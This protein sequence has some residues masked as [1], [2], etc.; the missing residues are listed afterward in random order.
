[1]YPDLDGLLPTGSL[2][3]SN[4]VLVVREPQIDAASVNVELLAQVFRCHSGA[5]D[6]PAWKTNAP[7]AGPV[8]LPARF[9]V[10]PQREIFWSILILGNLHLLSPVSTLPQILHGIPL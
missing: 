9:A 6:M 1:M 2:A 8:H 4:L 7:G 3:L 10:F 5:L